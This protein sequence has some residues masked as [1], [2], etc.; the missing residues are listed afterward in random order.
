MIQVILYSP[1]NN[2]YEF[3]CL[4]AQKFILKIAIITDI[5]NLQTPLI[6]LRIKIN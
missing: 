1:N 6:I 2:L 5:I 3:N 4:E